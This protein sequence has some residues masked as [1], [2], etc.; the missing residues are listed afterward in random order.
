MNRF[1]IG[2]PFSSLWHNKEDKISKSMIKKW[3]IDVHIFRFMIGYF[4]LKDLQV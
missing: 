1:F 2:I 4:Y 3:A